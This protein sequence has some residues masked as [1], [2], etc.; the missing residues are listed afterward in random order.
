MADEHL[1]ILEALRVGDPDAAA[2]VMQEHIM[3]IWSL[4][5]DGESG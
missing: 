1:P 3:L 5:R 4:I 2:A